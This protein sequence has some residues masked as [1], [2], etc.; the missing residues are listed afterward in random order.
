VTIVAQTL[1]T[2]QDARCKSPRTAA[3][4]RPHRFAA[5]ADPG[6]GT[7]LSGLVPVSGPRRQRR[8]GD[9][10]G[11]GH[12][13]GDYDPPHHNPAVPCDVN[14][15]IKVEAVDALVVINMI[16]QKGVGPVPE[17]TPKGRLCDVN[18]DGGISRRTCC[19]SSTTSIPTPRGMAVRR[20][21]W[22][23]ELLAAVGEQGLDACGCNAA[24]RGVVLRPIRASASA[25]GGRDDRAAL[26]GPS[27]QAAAQDAQ[28]LRVAARAAADPLETVFDDL[29][30]TIPAWKMRSRTC[31]TA[32]QAASAQTRRISC[33]F[34]YF[35]SSRGQEQER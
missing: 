35:V 2:A 6:R 23:R 10:Y 20:R 19:A 1:V 3:S 33:L 13:A 9:R 18:A 22:S 8:P 28:P 5:A 11:L 29:A 25:R 32:K 15:D 26:T 27:R 16:N 30:G 12:R 21:G 24:D 31:S 17:G 4:L 14:G 34:D 7:D